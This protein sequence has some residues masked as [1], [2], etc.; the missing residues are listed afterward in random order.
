MY[1]RVLQS[2]PLAL[3][4]SSVS[5]SSASLILAKTPHRVFSAFP[6]RQSLPCPSLP[7]I[8][9][10]PTASSASAQISWLFLTPLQNTYAG[11]NST[12][13]LSA[14]PTP[15]LRW[16]GRQN[17]CKGNKNGM[18]LKG[19]HTPPYHP[20][21]TSSH[22]HCNST[23]LGY[24]ARSRRGKKN[25]MERWGEKKKNL[26]CT[27]DVHGLSLPQHQPP[28]TY[29][30]FGFG[31]LKTLSSS[32]ISGPLSLGFS[33]SSVSYK[34]SKSSSTSGTCSAGSCS[35]SRTYTQDQSGDHWV[36]QEPDRAHI[37]WGPPRMAAH[38]SG[39]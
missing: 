35:E 39:E 4:S 32:S 6:E 14:I 2:V 17:I 9:K 23:H 24:Q 38:Q 22:S 11:F 7:L 30:N 10:F 34:R 36:C 1:L 15:V 21:L 29:F 13:C 20:Q 8:L 19:S 5:H 31:V 3:M 27:D 33:I 18:R 28:H 16:W 25:R 26:I 12:A 37:S